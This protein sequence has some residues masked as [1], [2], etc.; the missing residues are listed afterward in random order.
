MASLVEETPVVEEPQVLPNGQPLPKIDEYA[1]LKLT[2]MEPDYTKD[3]FVVGK[4]AEVN[5]PD[6][7]LMIELPVFEY[8]LHT[9]ETEYSRWTS[10]RPIYFDDILQWEESDLG[11]HEILLNKFKD[12]SLPDPSTSQ[13]GRRKTNRKS[14]RKSRKS[15]RR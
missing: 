7:K 12:P 11:K 15:R 14:R 9:G 8:L 2:P 13:G 10:K 6:G 5:I 1:R 4:I 3:E